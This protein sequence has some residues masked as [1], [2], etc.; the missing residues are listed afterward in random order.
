MEVPA[1]VTVVLMGVSGV[2]KSTVLAALLRQLA[3]VGAEGDAFH[4]PANVRKMRMGRPLDDADRRPWLEAVA[5]WIGRQE[6]ADRDAVVTCSAL[7][8]SYRDLLR[9]G[10]ASVWFA[11]LVAEPDVVAARMAGRRGHFMPP[12]LRQSQLASLEPLASDEPGGTFLADGQPEAVTGA[13]VM[14]LRASGRI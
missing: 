8:R 7:K 1:T 13:I 14:A 3:W 6:A 10:H 11:H 12:T 5:A 4:P 9:S 2:G